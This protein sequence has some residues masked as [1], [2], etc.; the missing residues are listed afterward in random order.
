MGPH[1]EDLSIGLGEEREVPQLQS[2]GERRWISTSNG[3]GSG[4]VLTVASMNQSIVEVDYAVRG[5]LAIRS[6]ELRKQLEK[7]PGS[8]PFKRIVTCNIGNPQQLAQKPITFFR[9]VSSLVDYPDLLLKKNLHITKQ[10]FAEDAITRSKQLLK[11][12]GGS[13]GAYSHSQGIPLVREHV[14][15]FIEERDGYPSDPDDIFLTAGASPG[16]QLV[17]HTLMAH[18]KVGIMIPIPQYP[19]YTATISMYEGNAVPYYLNEDAKWGLSLSELERSHEEATS[20]GLEVRALVVINPGN[21]TGGCLTQEN[22]R[23][24]IDFCHRKRIVLLAD[25]VYQAN[26]WEAQSLPF[27]SFKKTARSMGSQYDDLE[28]ISF[29]SVSKGMVGE[30]GRRG[31]Y[32]ECSGIDEEVKEMFYK[33][34]SI[35]LCPPV[36]GQ[37]MVDLMVN[38]PRKGEPSHQLYQSEIEAIYESLKRRARKLA[39]ALNELEGVTCNPAQGAMYLFPQ[40]RLP[41]GAVEAAEKVGRKADEFYCLELLNATGVCVVPGSGFRQRDGTW[42]FRS[43]FLPPEKEMDEFISNIATFHNNFLNRF[44]S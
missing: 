28:L 26:V 36:Q 23:E 14:T 41:Q 43:T 15:K 5:E 3:S 10:L 19:L 40:I 1:A 13:S 30:C 32:F 17:L 42:H 24:I 35:S 33:V 8:L 2:F 7:S 29:H 20:K 21:P 18:P 11:A 16:V 31:G 12:M 6:E 22:M 9:Q 4:K 44:R 37:V 25:E 39:D 27:H 38:P 34:C